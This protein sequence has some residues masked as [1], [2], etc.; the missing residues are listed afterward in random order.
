MSNGIGFHELG[1]VIVATDDMVG[2]HGG[3]VARGVVT[4]NSGYVLVSR[5]GRAQADRAL[6]QWVWSRRRASGQESR[7]SQEKHIP[8][9]RVREFEIPESKN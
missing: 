6:T 1:A 3:N 9:E 7:N 2:A 8:Q 4:R 5:R